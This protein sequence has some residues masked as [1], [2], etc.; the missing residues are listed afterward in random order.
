MSWKP[1][2]EAVTICLISTGNTLSEEGKYKEAEQAFKEAIKISSK[3]GIKAN[4]Y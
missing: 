3:S 4:A 1:D 2:K